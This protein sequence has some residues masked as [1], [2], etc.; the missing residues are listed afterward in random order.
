MAWAEV[1]T[2]SAVAFALSKPEHDA[3]LTGDA[4]TC[5]VRRGSHL[6]PGRASLERQPMATRRS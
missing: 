6:A 1:M 3:H 4:V 2:R 5:E